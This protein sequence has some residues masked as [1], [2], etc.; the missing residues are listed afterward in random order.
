MVGT[1]RRVGAVAAAVLTVF[2]AGAAPSAAPA[3]GCTHVDAVFYTTDTV[4]LATELAKTPSACAD[5]YLTVGPTATGAPRGGAPVTTIHSLGPHFHALAEI[6][7]NLWT[8]YAGANGWN[9]AGIEVRRELRAAGYDVASGDG[10]AINEVGAPS[11]TQMGVDVLMNIGTARQN[12]RDFLR[13]LYTGD[14]NVPSR[15]L[16]FAADPLQVIGDLSQYKQDLRAWYADSAFWQDAAR[17]V[18]FWAQETYADARTWG[19][20]GSTTAE[21]RAYLDDYFLHGSRLAAGGD[22]R[23]AAANA[24]FAGAYTPVGNA[25]FRWPAPDTST[26]IGFGETDVDVPAM[27]SFVSAQTDAMRSAGPAR[28]GFAIVPRNASATESLAV[29]DRVAS[30]LQA[31]DAAPGACGDG[32]ASCAGTAA[33]AQFNDAWKTFANTLEGAH[34]VVRSGPVK[35]TFATVTSR[36]VTHV[37]VVAGKRG[38]Y[39]VET[40]AAY[41]A[42]VDVCVAFASGMH[43]PPRLVRVGGGRRVDVTTRSARTFVCGRATS[44]GRFVIVAAP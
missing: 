18:R 42:P 4:R 40:T 20:A 39:D 14:D 37:A 6:R 33:G 17:Y 9:A 29:E 34:V 41:R 15:G 13:G 25:S 16:V 3:T 21:R 5:Y 27:L 28:L 10:W 44:L 12:L 26:G 32:G 2:M 36:G 19:V 35:V 31:S 38:M 7:L 43:H 23:T 1:A 11:G 22:G 24:F 8:A 30:S